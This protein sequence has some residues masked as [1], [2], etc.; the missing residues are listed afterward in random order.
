MVAATCEP[1][2]FLTLG[3]FA[4]HFAFTFS[5]DLTYIP[6][7]TEEAT[8]CGHAKCDFRCSLSLSSSGI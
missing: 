6:S 8:T 2:H 1:R 4:Y 5:P 3:N 7:S